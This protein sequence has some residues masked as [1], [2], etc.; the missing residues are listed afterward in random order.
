MRECSFVQATAAAQAGVSVIQ[1]NIGRLDDWYSKH[2]G[3]IRDPKAGHPSY[4]SCSPVNAW[5]S[6]NSHDL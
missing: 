3:V 1:P 5:I 2:P 6:T 4:S